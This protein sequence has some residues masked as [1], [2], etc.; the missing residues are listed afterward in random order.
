MGDHRGPPRCRRPTVPPPTT[1][2][3]AVR[4]STRGDYACRA[5]LSLALR[6]DP[7]CPTSV[8]D[9]AERTALPQPY[10]EQILLAL[11]MV[12]GFRRD[13]HPTAA[14]QP[15]LRLLLR[16]VAE[17]YRF[18]GFAEVQVV[19][20]IAGET[21]LSSGSGPT[22]GLWLLGVTYS[23]TRSLDLRV[24]YTRGFRGGDGWIVGFV[25]HF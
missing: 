14:R 23:V 18:G 25:L 6:G 17:G 20:E 12:D 19:A 9:I 24:G 5:L 22:E 2:D 13:S 21:G 3:D 1:Y 4:V 10:L 7:A 15:Y 16:E 8:R 11:S